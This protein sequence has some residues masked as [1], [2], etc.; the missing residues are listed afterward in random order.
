MEGKET[1]KPVEGQSEE[2][3]DYEFRLLDADEIEVRVGQGG[4]SKNPDWCTLLLYKDA[5]CDMRRLDE[6]FGVYGWKRKHEL[7]GNNLY[8]TVSVYKEGIGWIDKQDVGTPS[9]TEAVK[10]EASSAFKRA[11]TCLGVGRELYTAPKVIFINLNRDLEYTSSGRLKTTFHVGMVGYNKRRIS[12]LIIQDENNVIRWYFGMSEAEMLDWVKK[13]NEL[14]G[15]SE[16]AP[17]SEEEK[18]ESLMEQK[19][20]AYPQLQQAQ[21][22]EDVDKVWNGFPSLQKSNEFK[23]K[24]I[25]R[26]MELAQSRADLK[27]IYDSYPDM[28]GDKQFLAKLTQFKSQLR[29]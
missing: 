25:V 19:Q 21:L 4:N 10:G 7:I 17:K 9:Q 29:S 8:C 23:F 20:Y 2:M 5:R 6:K 11:C 14:H 1:K 22:W 12:Q 18:D 28:R 24:C 16:P 13:Q 27:A 15:Y 3:K 26:K